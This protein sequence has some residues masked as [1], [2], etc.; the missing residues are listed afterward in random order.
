MG[1]RK[2]LKLSFFQDI[3]FFVLNY[4]LS[5]PEHA[6][7]IFLYLLHSNDDH[8]NLAIIYPPLKVIHISPQLITDF[9]QKF[10]SKPC[11][12]HSQI[13]EPHET[14]AD[15]SP[16]ILDPTPSKIQ[17]RYS[18]LKSPHILHNF[19]PKHY[20]YLHV[21]DGEPNATTAEKHIQEFEHFIDLFEIDHDDVYMRAFSRSLKG[22][23]KDWFKHLQPETISS[24]EELKNVF[25]KFW[26]KKKSLDLQLTEFY[27]LKRQ[28]NE[29]IFTFSRRFSS[30]YYNLPK[31]I[32]PIEATAMLHYATTFHPEVSFLLM[33]R[34]PKSLQQM[35]NDAQE[36][37]HNIQAC[38]QIR[39]KESNAKE[40]GSEYEQ[41]I[42]DWNLE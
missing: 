15:V 32:Q 22:D 31:E 24:W 8:E 23:T 25:L 21:F 26:G 12:D 14:K 39:N 16:L 29:T 35:F 6:K 4:I 3:I 34:R 7:Q 20:K 30:I 18:P 41:K 11:D 40:H 36:I 28:R 42:V 38:K 5:F 17:H 33:E 1:E 19:P 10:S 13:D 37:Q 27:A 2:Y 9:D